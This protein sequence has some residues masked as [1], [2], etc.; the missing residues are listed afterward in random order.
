MEAIT[1]YPKSKEQMRAFEQVIN[2][3]ATKTQS[4][5]ENTKPY[6]F[7]FSCLSA[8]VAIKRY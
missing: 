7:E 4:H 6:L 1:I 5:K 2:F 3:Y 8:F